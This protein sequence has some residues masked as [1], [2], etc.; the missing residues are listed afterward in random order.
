MTSGEGEKGDLVLR[1]GVSLEG[2]LQAGAL[3]VAYYLLKW[4]ARGTRSFLGRAM[5]RLF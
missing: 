1:I 4:G 2:V 5:R 3:A